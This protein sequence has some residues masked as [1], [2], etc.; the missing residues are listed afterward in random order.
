MVYVQPSLLGWRPLV[1]S[2]MGQL[3]ATYS[4]AHKDTL[5]A[6]CDWL[7]PPT[8]RLATRFLEQ[9]VKQQ[10]Q[11]LVQSLLRICAAELAP[12]FAPREGVAPLAMEPSDV[13]AA[14]QSAFLFALVWS[15]GASVN[16]AGRSEF[17]T[18]LRLYLAEQCASLASA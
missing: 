6:L 13:D 16:E 4:D 2:W 1:E 3:P 17:D 14:V 5:F 7:L 12:I 9:P 15:C 10:E 11:I 18:Q 8:L